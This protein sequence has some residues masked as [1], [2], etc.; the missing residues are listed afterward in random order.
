MG[1]RVIRTRP[2]GESGAGPHG[3]HGLRRTDARL[4]RLRHEVAD[5][6]TIEVSIHCHPSRSGI[7]YGPV[8]SVVY[9]N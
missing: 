3:T 5:V 1:D 4:D 9:S 2:P 7:V 8:T 6:C